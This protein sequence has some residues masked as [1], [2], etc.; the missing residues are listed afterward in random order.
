MERKRKRFCRAGIFCLLSALLLGGCATGSE[1]PAGTTETRP[2]AYTEGPP[3]STVSETDR[4]RVTEAPTTSG[5]KQEEL[6][7]VDIEKSN[8]AQKYFAGTTDKNAVSY[9][10]GEEIKFTVSLR[11]DG[12]LASCA[13][14]KYI[15]KADDGRQPEEGFADG[16][17]GVFTLTTKLDIPGFVNLQVIACN[18]DGNALSGVNYF[19]GG[20]GVEIEKLQKAKAEPDDFDAF[21][22]S[23]LAKLEGVT[24]ELMEIREVT[25]P[26]AVF[27][28]YAVKIRFTEQNTWGNYVSAYLSVPKNA[29]AGSLVLNVNYQGAGVSDL[30]KR[31]TKGQAML[32]VS[33]HSMELGRDS[34]YYGG[35]MNST[36]RDYP[37]AHNA[38]RDTVYFREMVLRDIQAVRFMK[39]YFG[40]SG[41]DERFRGLWNSK[42]QLILSGGSQGGFQA[43]AVAALESG[44]SMLDINYPWLCDIGGCG[45]NGRM[46]STFMPTYTPALEYYDTVNFAKRLTCP[47][48]IGIEGLGDDIATT[49]GVT[50]FWNSLNPGIVRRITYVQNQSHSHFPIGKTDKFTLNGTVTKN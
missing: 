26:D 28:V 44:V 24:P 25:S 15:L 20:A 27:T 38:T 5:E 1:P 18:K 12:A 40:E 43:V 30:N 33:A 42:Q 39:Q 36:L 6:P 35:L 37:H 49:T 3:E 17:T 19:K 48:Y 34:S 41:A 31:C 29:K 2:R 11:A 47:T 50:V 10:A 4:G 32:T 23:Q 45:T 16:K 46:E 8:A 13:K 21:W 9:Q 22:H 14:F 7:K